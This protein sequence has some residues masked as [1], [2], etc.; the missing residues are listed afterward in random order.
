[1]VFDIPVA[2]QFLGFFCLSFLPGYIAI[3]LLKLDGLSLLEKGLF[4]VGLSLAFL[5]L[6]GLVLNELGLLLGISH[7]LSLVPLVVSLTVCVLGGGLFALKSEPVGSWK[8]IQIKPLLPYLAIAVIPVIGIAGAI[9]VDQN[10]NNL[11]AMLM[12]V[13]ICV[14]FA[15]VLMATKSAR[16]YPFAILII[17]LALL[18]SPLFVSKYMISFGSDVPNEFFVFRT[19]LTK[20]FWD[21][22]PP[23][24]WSSIY[25]NLNSML[26]LTILPTIYTILLKL[27]PTSAFALV[28]PALFALVPVGLYQ[29]WRKYIGERMSFVS[30]FLF[31]AYGVFFSEMLALNRQMIAELFFVLL[32]AT[33]LHVK[34]GRNTKTVLF[35]IFS[36]ALVTSHYALAVIVAFFLVFAAVVLFIYS[37]RSRKFTLTMV[38]LFLAVMF[39]WYIYTS[40]SSVLN[41]LVYAKN[42]VSSQLGN[43]FSPSS[44]GQ[45]V[46]AGLGLVQA[47]SI[48][49]TISRDFTYLTEILIVIGLLVTILSET[50]LRSILGKTENKFEIDYYLF[51][52]ASGA[53]LVALIAVPGLANVLDM[54]R[55]YQI[56]LMF[57]APLFALGVILVV[58]PLHGRRKEVVAAILFIIILVPYFLFNCGFIYEVT[59][60][61]SY[62]PSSLLVGKSTMSPQVLYGSFG[63]MDAYSV[64]GS[65][66]LSSNIVANESQVYADLVSVG[67][68]TVYGH[69]YPGTLNELSNSTIVQANGMVYMSTLNVVYNSIVG[70]NGRWNSSSASFLNNLDLVYTNGGSQVYANPP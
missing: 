1:V 24:I 2:R 23:S 20:G 32:L 60:T 54:D 62:G 37:R 18:Y 57:L 49:N 45:T 51:T 68:L 16:V 47:P 58:R 9:L 11:V 59:K 44:R 35:V 15:A 55:F 46:L 10:G 66:W 52:L 13:A 26:S 8:A 3:K 50:R 7:P 29:T 56:L 30:A 38:L 4:S 69:I 21:V 43:F 48:W 61:Q 22:T 25:P 39:V 6:G 31:M 19:T 28:F 33:A 70:T 14:L 27:D 40:N 12:V 17:A 41:S 5:M 63:Y 53:L 65:T 67:I 42:S 36:L 34:I 64:Y